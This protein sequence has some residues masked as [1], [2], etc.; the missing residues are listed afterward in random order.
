MAPEQIEGDLADARTDIWSFGCVLYEMVTGRKAFEGKSHA[1]LIASILEKH[2]TPMAE[3]QPM[4]PP[5]LGRIV[6]TCL[7][8]NP[9]DRFQT[10]HDLATSARLDRGRRFGRGPAGAG[11]RQPQAARA[12]DVWRRGAAVWASSPPRSPGR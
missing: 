12:D 4:T 9:D 10:A 7:A 1:S 2:P 8:K 5:A 6:R 3:L 11:R